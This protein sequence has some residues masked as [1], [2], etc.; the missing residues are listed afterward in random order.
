MQS[1]I[2]LPEL[3]LSLMV[4]VLFFMS[5]GKQVR[6]QHLQATSLVL[7][8][9]VVIASAMALSQQG[10]LFYDA[11]QVDGLSQFFK[12]II[13]FGL[14]L[15]I[16][17]GQGLLGIEEDLKPEYHLF[18]SISALGLMFLSSSVELLTILL[19][20]EISSYGLYVVIPFR[21]GEARR[22]Q[23]E[24]GIKYVL[25][26][27][28]STGITLFGM[29]YLFGTVKTT[30]VAEIAQ[31]LPH[32]VAHEPLAILG[33]VLTLA[34]FFYKLAM[35][36]MHFWTPD[37]YQ[38]AA[39]ETTAF[40]ATLPK[41]GAVVL[42]IRLIDLVGV[43]VGQVSWI[44][45]ALAVVSMTFGNIVALVQED[46][47]RLLAYSSIAHAGYL[48]VGLISL[49][50]LGQA[51][52]A[53]YIL[54]YLLMNLACFYVVYN[55]APNGENVTFDHLKG[56]FKKSP[57]MAFTLA[58]GA[59]GMAGIP[60]TVGFTG[61]F[62]LFTAALDSGFYGVVVIA[63]INSAIALFYYLK[64]VRAAYCMGEEANPMTLGI[65]AKVLGVFLI[66]A[67]ILVGILPQ[68]FIAIAKQAVAGM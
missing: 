60:P 67:I 64:M 18:L 34:G 16:Y 53:Y 21:K 23:T 61:K 57:V 11:Y 38:G 22:D 37:V 2:F 7:A 24:A 32:L 54:G 41:V 43:H 35:F 25:F 62:A 66:L 47:K 29:S 17:M 4:L 56:L 51:A 49:N 68:S 12:V 28:A 33:I 30:Y 59:F 10:T 46:I 9:L 5:L 42:L 48:M 19:S 40:V 14:F 63:V 44:L 26:G 15:V 39:N 31:Q 55:L 36:P 27:A 8:A 1:M 3:V 13:G 65:S 20:L 58:A 50:N 45:A 52:A 6:T